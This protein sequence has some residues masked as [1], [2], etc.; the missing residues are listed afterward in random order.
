M[1]KK[2]LVLF[3]LS[4]V[5]SFSLFSVTDASLL[6]FGAG[7]N[8]FK[9]KH[10]TTAEFRLEYKSYRDFLRFRPLVGIMATPKGSVYTYGGVSLDLYPV[11]RF[12]FAPNFAAGYYHQGGGKDL[13]YPLEFRTGIDIAIRFYNY[14]RLG[15]NVCHISNAQLGR[16]NPGMESIVFFYSLPVYYPKKS[17]D[18]IKKDKKRRESLTCKRRSF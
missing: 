11:N 14:S 6:S 17:K 18:K 1:T 10:H 3:C 2:V 5:Y 16:K 8:D 7:I 15:L 4:A 12:V 13:G 9:R